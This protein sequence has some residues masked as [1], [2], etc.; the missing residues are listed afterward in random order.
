MRIM[1]NAQNSG[2]KR[3][4]SR[5]IR[6]FGFA[7]SGILQPA[8]DSC[9]QRPAAAPVLRF[10]AHGIL[11]VSGR[12]ACVICFPGVRWL[13]GCLCSAISEIHPKNNINHKKV[14]LIL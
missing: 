11:P 5:I 10:K 13:R 1:V 4:I 7:I 8:R 6:S 9:S 14:A 2:V 12:A 3:V